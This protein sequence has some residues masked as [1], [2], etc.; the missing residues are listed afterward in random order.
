MELEEEVDVLMG[1]E[2]VLASTESNGHIL[3]PLDGSVDKGLANSSAWSALANG[4]ASP[5]RKAPY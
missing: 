2:A 5:T 4:E 1:D 3:Q